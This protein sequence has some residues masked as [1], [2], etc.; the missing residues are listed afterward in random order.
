MAPSGREEENPDMETGA[1]A[2]SSAGSQYVGEA[3]IVA[4]SG[5]GSVLRAARDR[6]QIC[7]KEMGCYPEARDSSDVFISERV[8]PLKRIHSVA[9]KVPSG[10]KSP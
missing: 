4:R 5:A 6:P 2:Q 10:S 9:S 8:P 3:F 7:A 1:E